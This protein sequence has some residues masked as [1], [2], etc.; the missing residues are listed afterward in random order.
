MI[1]NYDDYQY[2][3][4]ERV[5]Y[6]L[7]GA[8]IGGGIGY[9]FYSNIVVSLVC[10]SFGFVYLRGKKNQLIKK[11]KW[12]LNLEFRDGLASVTAALQ[13]GYSVENA[14]IQGAKDLRL[15]YSA[16]ALIVVE[17]DSIVHQLHMNQSLEDVVMDFGERSKVSD[18]LN[19]ARVLVTAKR[20]GGDL[21]RIIRATEK[22]ISDKIE[23][24]REIMTVISGKKLESNI[25]CMIPF[26]IIVYLRL[27]TS[28]F[29]DPLYH[30]PFGI[31]FMTVL[32]FFYYVVYTIAQRITDIHI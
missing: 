26:G 3:N 16:N 22:T 2:T 17:F 1:K 4:K 25:M 9:L 30:S 23:V 32:L 6:F 31:V 11:R 15:M 19:F 28:G 7:Q 10:S 24:N 29:L 21:I 13:A 12:N 14:F 8:M 20:T 5:L 18:I 27:F